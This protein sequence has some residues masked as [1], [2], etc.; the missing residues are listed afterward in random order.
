MI[1]ENLKFIKSLTQE[2]VIEMWRRGE[3]NVEHWKPFWESKGH[4]SWEE[5]RRTTHKALFEKSLT[6][7]L[8]N[9]LNPLTT[10]PEWQGGMFHSWSK[11]FYTN[12]PEKPPKLKDLLTH[13]GIHNHWF[14]REIAHNFKDIETT[15]MATRSPSGTIAIAEGMH[16][17]CAITL[18]A[19]EK[20]NL[21]TKVLVM[22]ASWS[23][24]EP[25]KLG[26]WKK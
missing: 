4:K 22:V 13:P 10:I 12:F 26:H 15:L 8:Y 6:W 25:P 21:D 20:I 14:V 19:N 5:W 18:M 16:R 17:A 2:E 1:M 23:S 24:E 11:W 7:G 3:K 9:V